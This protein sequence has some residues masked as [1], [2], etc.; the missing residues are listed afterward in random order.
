[1]EIVNKGVTDGSNNNV[2]QVSVTDLSQAAVDQTRIAT[3]QTRN[4]LQQTSV[5]TSDL[6]VRSVEGVVNNLGLTKIVSDLTNDPKFLARIDESVKK[7][8]ADGKLDATDIPEIVYLIMDAYNTIG[9]IKVT[10]DDLGSFV[11][12][13][14]KFVVDKY[15]LLPS[16]KFAEYELMLMSSVKLV[17]LTPQVDSSVKS[18]RDTLRKLF[19]CF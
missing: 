5:N 3:Q 9:S 7:M 18:L 17:L 13:I 10:K 11:K 19:F 12:L 4:A 8:L 2:S 6:Q 1:M 16:D 14:F 15:N